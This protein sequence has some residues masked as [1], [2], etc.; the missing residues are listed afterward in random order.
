[1]WL[2]SRVRTAVAKALA[3]WDLGPSVQIPV[4]RTTRP[5][6]GDLSTRVAFVLARARGGA[7]QEIAAELASRLAGLPVFRSVEAAGG[8]VNFSL[9]PSTVHGALRRVLADG[10]RYGRGSEGAGKMV[11][12]EFISSN[13]TGPLTVGHLRQAAG[14]RR[15]RAV[16]PTWMGLRPQVLP[17]R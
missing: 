14:R 7:P 16:R 11:Q 8:F 5:E 6:H 3:A 9:H 10:V 15:R 1:M 12:V 4:E 13:P 17:E 2:E